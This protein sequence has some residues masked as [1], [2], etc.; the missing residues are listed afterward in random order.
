[1]IRYQR[2]ID[3]DLM[4][5]DQLDGLVAF[6]T[7]ARTRSFTAAA[8]ELEVSTQ[9]VSQGVKALETRLSVR[10]FNRTTR[11]VALTEAGERLWARVGPALDDVMEATESVRELAEKPTG[12]LRISLPRLA[13][14]GLVQPHLGRFHAQY[15][16]IALELS[17]DDGFIDI[18]E[19]G[20]DA[21]IRLGDAVARD[22]VSLPLSSREPIVIVASPAYLKRRGTPKQIVDLAQHDCIR[23]RFPSTEAIFRW[24]LLDNGRPVEVEVAG[25]VTVNDPPSMIGCALEGLGLAYVFESLARDSLATGKLKRVLPAACPTLPG[26]HLYFPSRRQL[27]M[28]LR[29]FVDFWKSVRTIGRV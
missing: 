20:L 28:K 27:P 16:G 24:E 25:P 14:G 18:V 21:G 13:F 23:F 9:A 8:A 7:V 3:N 29:C 15:P 2:E 5:I 4:R 12:L 1:L 6:R 26:L 10:L 22:M 11:S 19:R 17:F